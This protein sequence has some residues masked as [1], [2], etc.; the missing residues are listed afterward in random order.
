MELSEGELWQIPSS[1]EKSI[2][3]IPQ[4]GIPIDKGYGRFTRAMSKAANSII[5]MWLRTMYV[6]EVDM[7]WVHL[8][9]G[10]GCIFQHVMGW[11]GL[12]EKYC[13]TVAEY[14]KTHIFHCP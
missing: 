1:T 2:P 9:V 7:G 11:V 4:Y 10:L 13:G 3:I 8:W 12:N 14:C 5:P 6:P